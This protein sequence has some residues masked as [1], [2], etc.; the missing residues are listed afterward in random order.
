MPAGSAR[1]SSPLVTPRPKFALSL[2]PSVPEGSGRSSL[3]AIA[4]KAM[5]I[6]A[7]EASAAVDGIGI[8]GVALDVEPDL[9][10]RAGETLVLRDVNKKGAHAMQRFGIKD[11]AIAAAMILFA[12]DPAFAGFVT[13]APVMGAGIGALA[14]LGVGYAAIRQRRG[15]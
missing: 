12:A 9:Q 13:P 4:R 6:T 8:T 3:K 1:A 10:R 5:A 11:L 2:L 7:R 15:R 14:L